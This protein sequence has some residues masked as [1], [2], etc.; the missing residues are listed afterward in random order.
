MDWEALEASGPGRA[1][2]MD[3]LRKLALSHALLDE[4][5]VPRTSDAGEPL[6]LFGRIV[7]LRTGRFDPRKLRMPRPP[8]EE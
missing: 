5:G 1:A 6:S 3:D 4:L 7:A 2:L 8:P